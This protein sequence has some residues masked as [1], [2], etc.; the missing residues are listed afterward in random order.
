M[1]SLWEIGETVQRH[2]VEFFC[3]MAAE[4]ITG[5]RREDERRKEGRDCTVLLDHCGDFE[6]GANTGMQT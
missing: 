1:D 3:S 4:V 2:K 5:E 6:L